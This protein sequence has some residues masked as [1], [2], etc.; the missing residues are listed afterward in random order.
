[1]SKKPLSKQAKTRNAV[2]KYLISHGE[3]KT[4]KEIEKA[5][6]I[7]REKITRSISDIRQCEDYITLSLIK[8][9]RVRLKSVAKQDELWRTALNI[10]APAKAGKTK[11]ESCT[12]NT[13]KVRRRKS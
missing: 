7:S 1:M 13:S 11:N 8:P 5:I 4:P 2:I 12:K 9:F 10:R 3:Y 6:G